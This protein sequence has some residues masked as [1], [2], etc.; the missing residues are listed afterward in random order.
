M[1]SEAIFGAVRSVTKAWAK[2]RRAEEREASRRLRRY[3]VLTRSREVTISEAAW[4]VMPQAYLRA[5]SNGTLPAHARQIMYAARGEIQRLTGRQLND[6]YFTQTLLPDYLRQHPEETAGWDVVFDAR[7][8]L[9]E[10]HTGQVV[11]LGTIEVRRHLRA[12]ASH[13][14][15]ELDLANL[16]LPASFPTRGPEHRYGAILFVEKE[17]FMPL[18]EAV[19]LPRAG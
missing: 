13:Q 15:T 1:D 8:H 18:F 9:R 11:P 10:P 16:A 6:Q 2:Q 4:R 17:G 19:G 14:V 12:V 7:G 3:E 5:S